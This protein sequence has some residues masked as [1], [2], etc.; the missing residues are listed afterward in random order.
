MFKRIKSDRL[1]A[2]REKNKEVSSIL[3]TLIG[4]I[5]SDVIGNTKI[6]EITDD[7][8]IAKIKK[9][10]KSLNELLSKLD[11]DSPAA[12]L[13]NYELKILNSYLPSQL[14][15]DELRAIIIDSGLTN[16]GEIM[17]MLKSNYSGLFD[18]KM[19]SSIIKEL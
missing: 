12:E 1:V 13:P 4:E 5:E 19:A 10:S 7:V 16:I 14:T 8:V 18:G 9:F 6:K 17:K 2:R 15:E 3:T 11:K